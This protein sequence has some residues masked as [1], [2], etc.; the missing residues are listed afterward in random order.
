MKSKRLKHKTKNQ[1][2]TRKKNRR[3]KKRMIGA[4]PTHSKIEE[5][6]LLDKYETVKDPLDTLEAGTSFADALAEID[7]ES[8][9]IDN[10]EPTKL[11]VPTDDALEPTEDH[12]EIILPEPIP[13]EYDVPLKKVMDKLQRRGMDVTSPSYKALGPYVKFIY[14][15]FIRKYESPC[16]LYN[17]QTFKH[18]AVLHY[19]V[20][21]KELQFPKNL[22]EQI[23][24]CIERG[25]EV[26]FITLYMKT[27]D[28]KSIK[29][30]NL[31]IYRPFKKVIEHYEPH[32]PV[33]STSSMIF[34]S[35]DFN[36][37]LINLFEDTMRPELREYTPKFKPASDL[38][39]HI[40]FQGIEN[41]TPGASKEDGYCQMWTMFLMETILLN[42]TQNTADIIQECL[43]IGESRPL[44]FKQ[45]IRGYRQ[46]IA[47]ELTDYFSKYVKTPIGTQ[48]AIDTM[49]E[50]DYDELI[51]EMKEETSQRR[52][53]H[54]RLQETYEYD[55]ERF[56][57]IHN[58]L[59]IHFLKTRTIA[60][61][62][63]PDKEE[64]AA[65]LREQQLTIQMLSEL[66]YTTYFEQIS[67]QEMNNVMYFSRYDEYINLKLDL[68]Y[69]PDKIEETKEHIKRIYPFF[70]LFYFKLE[71]EKKKKHIVNLEDVDNYDRWQIAELYFFMKHL[72]HA[73][74]EEQE[75]NPIFVSY[76]DAKTRDMYVEKLFEF[77]KPY[78]ISIG[79][80]YLW[81][82]L[83]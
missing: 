21:R 82:E 18:R 71:N 51:A 48:E 35:Y 28:N 1:K 14:A 24:E 43:D 31:L 77:L 45:L 53:P 3:T 57:P 10:A 22:G 70:H 52:R 67:K 56:K 30:V 46:K 54:P 25:T 73:T 81:W 5:L 75:T 74:R 50:I 23:R 64:L 29:H 27:S 20:T 8:V 76:N 44:Y 19:D 34:D 4:G 15:Y 78:D 2:K 80:L 39:P 37:K 65:L 69:P 59:Y 9:P 7:K 47:Y 11:H 42:P 49:F 36:L 79:D 61:P 63:I 72:R 66:M 13:V 33:M 17:D 38:C 55:M 16:F 83:F 68:T 40:G 60:I 32:G 6:D 26:I 41:G 12:A 58:A 62:T